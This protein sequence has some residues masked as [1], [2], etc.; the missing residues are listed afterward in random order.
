MYKWSTQYC[1]ILIPALD[2]CNKY[3]NILEGIPT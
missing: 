1:S 3:Q 2:S